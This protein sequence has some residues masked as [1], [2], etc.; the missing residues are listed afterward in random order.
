ML[1]ELISHYAKTKGIV[2]CIID[3]PV[4]DFTELAKWNIQ[5]F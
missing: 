5:Y 2:G 3:G 1:G 4:R